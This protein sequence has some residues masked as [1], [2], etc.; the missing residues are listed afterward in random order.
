MNN[1]CPS[2]GALYN[3]ASK[4][5]GRKIKCKKCSTALAVTDAG[6]VV[7]TPSAA[8]SA[9]SAPAAPAPTAAV[10]EEENRDEPVVKKKP[11]KYSRAPGAGIDILALLPTIVFGFG[12]F[13]V[14]VFISLP[15]IGQAGSER[16]KAYR[17]RLVNEQKYEIFNLKPKKKESEWSESEKKKIEEETPKIEAKYAR[18][19]E[20]AELDAERTRI[21]NIRQVWFEQYGLMFG[22]ILVSFGCIAFLR[23]EQVLVVK[24]V[25]AVILC[26]MMMIMFMKFGGCQG[27][28]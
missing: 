5:I 3:V 24:I 18:L 17:D 15:I 1:T 22:F 20:E 14:I 11:S 12:V 2:C 7:D 4:D 6:L 8:A 21:S 28:R 10:V 16:D 19:I 27:P 13:M 23:T 25:A 26:F 9:L